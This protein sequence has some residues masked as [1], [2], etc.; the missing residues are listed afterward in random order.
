M[1]NFSRPPESRLA[2][3][4][5]KHYVGNRVQQGVPLLDAD[6]H[7]LEGLHRSELEGVARWMLG[8]G[9]PVGSDGFRVLALGGGGVNTVVLRANTAGVAASSIQVDP[10]ASTAAAALGFGPGN[11][12]AA[13]YGNAP[14]QLTSAKAEPFVLSAGATL[15][16]T[17]DGGAPETVTF[18][19]ADFADIA[20]ATAA[21]V[22]AKIA[23]TVTRVT[24][25]VGAGN[26]FYLTGGDGTTPGAGRILVEGRMALIERGLRYTEQ[27]LY[28]NAALATAWGVDPVG[29]IPTPPVNT[30]QNVFL[31][32]WH[33]EVDR[34]ED[35][36]LVDSRIGIETAVSLRREWAVRV[37]AA[38]DYA[39]VLSARPAGHSY[40]VL[41][42]LNRGA[43]N[44]AIAA[45][46]VVDQR[47]TDASLRRQVAYRNLAGL[48]VVDT[49]RFRNMLALTRDAARGFITYLTT[50]FV[51]PS[52]SYLAAE[53]L[54]VES[55]SAVASAADHAL[56]IVHAQVLGTRGAMGIVQQIYDAEAR[57]VQAWQ[58]AL[59]PLVKSG[60][61]PYQSAFGASIALIASY[62]DGP[63][64]GG[65]VAVAAALQAANLDGAV[66]S[67]E[68]IAAE[69]GAQAGKPIGTLTVKYLGSVSPTVL[70]ASPID[71]KFE[72]S[73][74]V[75]PDDDLAV[76]VFIDPLWT[77]SFKNGDGST[78]FSLQG[79]P[80]AFT[81]QFIVTV[82]PPAGP[83]STLFSVEVHAQRNPALGF[84]TTQKTLQIG[85]APPPS[86][87][88]Y[89]VKVAT[90]SVMPSGGVY[91]VPH[92]TMADITLV[93][94]NHSGSQVTIDLE[95][96]ASAVWTVTK[97]PFT[98][99]N[100]GNGYDV[101][102]LSNSP[103]FL[104]HFTAPATAGVALSFTLKARDHNNPATV[105]AEATV[106]LI[107][108]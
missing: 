105:L 43:N 36:D 71:L 17:A 91:Q 8:D 45:T 4:L 40:Y 48:V 53:M 87:E 54:G 6:L 60:A 61:T 86:D 99:N 74:A 78:P 102:A 29:P 98:L 38:A 58:T 106:S 44:P 52:S 47:D 65:N 63:A 1:G 67:Q 82:T 19:A 16:I 51:A 2:D 89:E 85:S 94:A 77:V 25:S 21:E 97:G 59:L 26:D 79:G 68:R 10:A 83:G 101:A 20:A 50:Q 64:P 95:P 57:L 92:S 107:S 13:R 7:L 66:A 24:P 22:V 100:S 62:L 11:A 76:Q 49:Q 73:G 41:A 18:Q 90:A 28:Q 42:Q 103:D 15:V 88:Q 96:S 81:R 84:I 72:V 12:L 32:V 3:A 56:G 80:G 5:A 27:P 75:T 39:A 33:R 30:V 70:A 35:A 69:L 93:F 9:V 108:T 14:A 34:N 46:I 104:W 55:L 37:A 31:D 23:A